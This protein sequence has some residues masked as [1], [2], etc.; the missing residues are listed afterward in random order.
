MTSKEFS[1]WI[2]RMLLV[3]GCIVGSI[4]SIALFSDDNIRGGVFFSVM[5]SF[6]MALLI[7]GELYAPPEPHKQDTPKKSAEPIQ[8]IE[9]NIP[10]PAYRQSTQY[11]KPHTKGYVYLVKALHDETLFKIGRTNSPN[12]RMRTFEVKLPFAIECE[13]LI[14][15]DDM[16]K[17]EGELHRKFKPKRLDGEFFRLDQSD[18][19]YI[20]NLTGATK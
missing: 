17:L 14:S 12:K 7:A 5:V 8:P 4:E 11:K 2:G 16:Y 9:Y 20:K 18:V 1:M 19:E 13:C 6:S 3:C 10:A 15:T